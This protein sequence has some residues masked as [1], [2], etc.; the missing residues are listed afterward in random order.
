MCAMPFECWM[1]L[2]INVVENRV[3]LLNRI[4]LNVEITNGLSIAAIVL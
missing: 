1:S 3:K 2:V 4:Q